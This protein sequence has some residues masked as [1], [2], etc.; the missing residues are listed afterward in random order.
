MLIL[1]LNYRV[2]HHFGRK[3]DVVCVMTLQIQV[4]LLY[5]Q[6]FFERNCPILKL[7]V[8]PPKKKEKEKKKRESGGK[9]E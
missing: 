2:V 7:G 3:I 8:P 6:R 1:G 5:C 4:H 9:K